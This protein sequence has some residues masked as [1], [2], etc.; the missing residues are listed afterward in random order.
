MTRYLVHNVYGDAQSLIDSAPED[1]VCV[2]FGWTPQVEE[3]RN[4][5]FSQLGVSGVS[6]LPAVLFFCPERTVSYVDEQ[7]ATQSMLVPPHWREV[8]VQDL[9]QPWTWEAIAQEQ[10]VVAEHIWVGAGMT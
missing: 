1:V 3:A 5:L 9:Q 10:D 6:C 2:P 4:N 8:R 7:G